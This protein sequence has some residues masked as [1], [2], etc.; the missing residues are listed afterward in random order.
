MPATSPPEIQVLLQ[1]LDTWTSFVRRG[2]ADPAIADDVL[3][4]ALS[5]ALHSVGELRDEERLTAWFYRVLRNAI[6]D[7]YRT[8]GS[9][10]RLAERVHS[11]PLGKLG[12]EEEKA[13]CQCFEEL[14]D[15]LPKAQAHLIRELDLGE[16]TRAQLAEE[17]GISAG[18]LRVR[19]HRARHSLRARLEETCRLCA[20]HGCLDCTCG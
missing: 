3:Q 19:H 8:H 13:L 1:D 20:E 10:A 14:L 17:L 6:T 4:D 11:D 12:P 18:N 2:I 16:T 15:N 5:K 9:R 7:A